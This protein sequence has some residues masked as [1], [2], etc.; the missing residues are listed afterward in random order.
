M[1]SDNE[2]RKE[3]SEPK[4]THLTDI[5]QTESAPGPNDDGFGPDS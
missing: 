2:G 4:I 1:K 5:S 3:W